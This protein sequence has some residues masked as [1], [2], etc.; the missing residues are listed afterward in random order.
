MLR[1][2]RLD[3]GL[4]GHDA[5]QPGVNGRG[6]N[7]DGPGDLFARGQPLAVRVQVIVAKVDALGA[8][9]PR[10]G[11]RERAAQRDHLADLLRALPGQLP[12]IDP[13]QAPAHHG[14]RP[15]GA[16]RERVQDPRQPIQDGVG[17]ADV[18]PEIPAAHLIAQPPQELPEQG[19]AP[20]RGQ[21]SGHDQHP[22]TVAA[23][24]GREPR[25]SQGQSGQA[26][27][28]SGGLGQVEPSRRSRHLDGRISISGAVCRSPDEVHGCTLLP[29]RRDHSQEADTS[30]LYVSFKAPEKSSFLPK[31]YRCRDVTDELQPRDDLERDASARPRCTGLPGRRG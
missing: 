29:H 15:A 11:Q 26:S 3:A 24:R 19:R 18:A 21:Q 10:V 23:R 30:L 14:D 16:L 6:R 8:A 7:G 1:R 25:R 27:Q 9:L 31:S 4:P 22:M 13:A 20:V 17:R 2:F 12:G 5:V 28:P